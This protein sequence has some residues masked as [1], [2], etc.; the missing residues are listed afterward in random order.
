MPPRVM[1]AIAVLFAGVGLVL[2]QQ[3]WVDSPRVRVPSAIAYV[4][5]AALLTVGLMVTLQVVDRRQWNDLLAAVLL[6][7]VTLELLWFT[8]GSG[9]R[10]CLLG[11][12]SPPE[13]VCRAGLAVCTLASA[14]MT[15]WAVRRHRARRRVP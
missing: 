4:I 12:W 10:P 2:A 14:V 8:V 1:L 3:A 15:G 6:F 13:R 11:W 9:P 5:A 7:A